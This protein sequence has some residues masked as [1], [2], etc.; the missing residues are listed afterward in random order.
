MAQR[1][2]RTEFEVPTAVNDNSSA[3][4]GPEDRGPQ[5]APEA[6]HVYVGSETL[7]ANSNEGAHVYVQSGK[8]MGSCFLPAPKGEAAQSTQDVP[9]AG[10]K[11]FSDF[12]HTLPIL[13]EEIALIET[14]LLDLI[15]KVHAN[16]NE[17]T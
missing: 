2:P 8:N 4:S 10:L 17:E 5:G 16:D 7:A 14:Y 9:G 1:L 3:P 13:P 15:A 11:I 12:P 6:A